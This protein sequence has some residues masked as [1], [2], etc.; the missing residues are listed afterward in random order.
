MA[1]VV[2]YA[3]PDKGFVHPP[4]GNTKEISAEAYQLA[5]R[6]WEANAPN[7]AIYEN[8]SKSYPL[9]AN[10]LKLVVA[11]D[12]EGMIWIERQD[13]NQKQIQVKNYVTSYLVEDYDITSQIKPPILS[14]E[15]NTL[16]IKSPPKYKLEFAIFKNN[17]LTSQFESSAG[18]QPFRGRTHFGNEA[19][20]LVVPS[21]T[22]VLT[23]Y[24]N[25]V[26]LN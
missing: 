20:H 7:Q 5:G 8:L 25:T 1:S 2:V 6:I 26:Y 17:F 12:Y 18:R 22:E 21:G 9:T 24:R 11:G 13:A 19:I 16:L 15:D 4:V 14:W 3:L 10:E 23:D